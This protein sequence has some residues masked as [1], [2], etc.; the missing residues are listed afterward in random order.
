QDEQSFDEGLVVGIQALLVS[1]DFLYRLERNRPSPRSLYAQAITQYELATRLSYF[2]WAS[3]PDETLRRAAGAG[4][5]RDPRVLAAQVR[6]MLHDPKADALAEQ[7]GGQ[8]LQFRALESL[9]RNRERFPD[10]EDYL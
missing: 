4:T 8:W 7:F 3:M 9:T 6:R 10:F 2:L 1:P 5:L